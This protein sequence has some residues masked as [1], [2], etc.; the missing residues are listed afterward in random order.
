MSRPCVDLTLGPTPSDRSVWLYHITDFQS[1]GVK[2]DLNDLNTLTVEMVSDMSVG[3]LIKRI[4][5]KG[6][7][8]FPS[9]LGITR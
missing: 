5:V 7:D 4:K 3:H 8:A 2:Q 1:N 6:V 9:L